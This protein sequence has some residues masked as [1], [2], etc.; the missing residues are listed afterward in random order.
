M[1]KKCDIFYNFFNYTLSCQSAMCH[2]EYIALKFTVV[3]I[4]K[5]S[6]ST[7]YDVMFNK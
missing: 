2:A 7:V 6:T 1:H 3:G 4:P 5:S